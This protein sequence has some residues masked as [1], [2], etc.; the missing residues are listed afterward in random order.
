MYTDT[1]PYPYTRN[2]LYLTS[3]TH[4]NTNAKTHAHTYTYTCAR[5]YWHAQ[6]DRYVCTHTTHT[7]PHAL[8][9]RKWGRSI[10]SQNNEHTLIFLCHW[11]ERACSMPTAIVEAC[12]RRMLV[13]R[14]TM[15][16]PLNLVFSPSRSLL[17]CSTLSNGR[18][19][20]QCDHVSHVDILRCPYR[21]AT[22]RSV[23]CTRNTSHLTVRLTSCGVLEWGSKV[24]CQLFHGFIGKAVF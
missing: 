10:F 11:H 22:K 21:R 20:L 7:Q 16:K 18:G 5:K 13:A 3:H 8:L 12:T 4:K 9:H 1:F 14:T 24:T 23:L 19:A 15:F 6:I 2:T 17:A